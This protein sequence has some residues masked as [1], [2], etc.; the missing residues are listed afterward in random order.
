MLTADYRTDE[1]GS[2]IGAETQKLRK[3]DGNHRE[4]LDCGMRN[5]VGGASTALTRALR[6]ATGAPRAA[7]AQKAHVNGRMFAY[8]RLCSLMFA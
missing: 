2:G 8:V 1:R 6:A 7:T 3:A 4:T 5:A